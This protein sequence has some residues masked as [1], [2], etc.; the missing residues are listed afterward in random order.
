MTN[1]MEVDTRYRQALETTIDEA[2]AMRT[3]LEGYGLSDALVEIVTHAFHSGVVARTTC[4]NPNP[5]ATDMAKLVAFKNL[6]ELLEWMK[7]DEGGHPANERLW[8]QLPTFGGDAPKSGTEEI[9]SWDH[10]RV[11]WGRCSDDI[12]IEARSEIRGRCSDETYIKIINESESHYYHT[13]TNLQG[14]WGVF[15]REQY[16]HYPRRRA[17]GGFATRFDAVKWRNAHTKQ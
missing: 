13:L 3:R 16:W 1:E 15:W 7:S 4:G 2:D 8:S 11:I 6:E 14:T 12:S 9:W 10:D 17:R 5:D